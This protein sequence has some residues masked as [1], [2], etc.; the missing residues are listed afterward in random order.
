MKGQTK[1]TDLWLLRGREGLGVWDQRPN[2]VY[3][4]WRNTKVLL[5]STG[6]SIQYLVIKHRKGH[7]KE[8][9]L[10]YGRN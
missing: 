7:E 5:Y 4:G 9:I 1:R 6:N 10:L 2:L 3:T 8:V